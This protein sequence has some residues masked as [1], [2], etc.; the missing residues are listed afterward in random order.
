VLFLIIFQRLFSIGYSLFKIQ[1]AN[2]FARGVGFGLAA[3]ML[4]AA[5]G[6]FFGDRWMYIEITGFTMTIAALTVRLQMISDEEKT[7][8]ES[9]QFNTEISYSLPE[10]LV[11]T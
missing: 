1:T 6:N 8:G 4:A 3:L 5:V 9:E 7:D 10:Q 11:E 2:N